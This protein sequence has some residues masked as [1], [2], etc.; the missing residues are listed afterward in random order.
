MDFGKMSDS[1]WFGFGIRHIPIS[2]QCRSSE[3]NSELTQPLPGRL[4]FIHLGIAERRS[5]ASFFDWAW[6]K[7]NFLGRQRI[8]TITAFAITVV[9]TYYYPHESKGICFYRRWF[10]CLCLSVTT[11]TKKIV[12]GFVP[13]FMRS[14]LG[15]KRKPSSCFVTIDRGMWK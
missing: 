5:I 11:I 13:N 15:G 8:L 3:G 4:F 10:V 12:D 7:G 2:Y 9:H 14:F 1:I 6:C